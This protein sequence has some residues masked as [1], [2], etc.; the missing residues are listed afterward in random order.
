MSENWDAVTLQ[1]NATVRRW[2]NCTIETRLG[3]SAMW[4]KEYAFQGNLSKK[5]YESLYL[6]SDTLVT[7]IDSSIEESDPA[8]D[9]LIRP[10]ADFYIQYAISMFK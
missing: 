8:D 3:T 1:D 4:L 9:D 5:E 6:A 10:L 7:W 2:K